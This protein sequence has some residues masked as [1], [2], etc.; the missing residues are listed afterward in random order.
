M[1]KAAWFKLWLHPSIMPAPPY[2][3]DEAAG[4]EEAR[5]DERGLAGE[6]LFEVPP[7]PVNTDVKKCYTD[8]IRYLFVNAKKWA[9]PP[10]LSPF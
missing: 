6:P 7:L 1:N 4:Q 8:M 9:S 3:V 10:P 5:N 2:F